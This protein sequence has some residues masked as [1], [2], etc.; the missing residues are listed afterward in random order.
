MDFC[1]TQES[2]QFINNFMDKLHGR[3]VFGKSDDAQHSV[4]L[5]ELCY[6]ITDVN[7]RLI[8]NLRNIHCRV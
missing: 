7:G 6:F 4:F 1:G 3:R 2:V 5:T 8:A